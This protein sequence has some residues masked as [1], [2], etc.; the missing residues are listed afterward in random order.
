M[1]QRI[2]VLL[3]FTSLM[4]VCTAKP[5]ST[6]LPALD[7]TLTPTTLKPSTPT[8]AL[9]TTLAISGPD[10][11]KNAILTDNIDVN[12]VANSIGGDKEEKYYRAQ[13][14]NLMLSY[15]NRSMDPCDDFYEYACGNWKSVI[16][17]RQS[18]HK[19]NNLIDIVYK[20]ADIAKEILER[21][22]INDIDPT[23]AEDFE[24]AKKFYNNCLESE[25][26]PM[27]KSQVYLDVIKKIGGFPAIDSTWNASEFSWIK[28]SAHMSNFG[29]KSLI[30][31]KITSQYP[32]NPYFEIPNFGFDIELHYDNI[33][34]SSSNAYKSNWKRMDDILAIYDVPAE[35]RTR[36][37]GDIFEFLNATLKIVEDFEED[38][39]ECFVLSDTVN[40]EE[41]NALVVQMRAYYQIA[42]PGGVQENV[43][44]IYR[45]C[46]YFY[47]HFEKISQEHATA[48]AN[49]LSLKFLYEMDPRLDS[50]EFH[51]DFCV[52]TLKRTMDYLFDHLYMKIYFNQDIRDDVQKMIKDIR[53]ALHTILIEADWLDEATREAAILKE[54]SMTEYVGRYEDAN[55]T[56][57]LLRE[58]KNLEFV[59][60]N[61]DQNMLN[62]KRFKQSMTRYNG[63]HYQELS[64]ATKPLD[65]LLGMQV[66]AFYYNIDNTII[67]TA[68]I[69]HPPAF[70]KSWPN[71]L[72]YATLGYFVGHEFTH[73]FDSVGAFYDGSGKRNYWWSEKSGKVFD[74]RSQCYVDHYQNYLIPEIKRNINGNNTKDENIADGGGLRIAYMAYQRYIKS[75]SQ[76]SK[77]TNI[78]KDEQMPGMDLTPEQLFFLGT[79][80]VWCSSYKEAHYWEELSDEHTIDKY[81]VLGLFANNEH[82]A[83]AYNCPK[84][85]RM[86]SSDDKCL[87]W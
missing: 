14:G 18:H 74:D 54:S 71:V 11:K 56:T 26:H 29:L 59:E 33:R 65:L 21:P 8:P 49:Y 44:V 22:H 7:L 66:N 13:Y 40:L 50:R 1:K 64:N 30:K 46:D 57:R 70:H 24:K 81:R 36:I 84:G 68:G 5:T 48:V 17:P 78:L 60:G 19:R 2:A 38:D 23:Y 69:L 43:S 28:M 62:M 76:D 77:T 16:K 3:T 51:T 80:Q 47:H 63:V 41:Y 15:M 52:Q 61:F 79:A 67:V 39:S 53:Q 42:W 6:P 37:I 58:L 34:N 32:F 73:G 45:P 31:E 12:D 55:M 72:K 10:L 4:S 20:L 87:I 83:K 85:S 75:I 27:R 35:Q 82:F 25:I 86:H 9:S